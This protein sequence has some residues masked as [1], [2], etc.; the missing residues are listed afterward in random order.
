MRGGSSPNNP[1]PD[2]FAQLD[3]FQSTN[4]RAEEGAK[5]QVCGTALTDE[6][7]KVIGLCDVHQR[8]RRNDKGG[9][10]LTPIDMPA[11]RWTARTNDGRTVGPMTLEDL[12][13]RIRQGELSPADE[14]S[15]DGVSFLPMGKFQEIAYLSSIGAAGDN[16]VGGVPRSRPSYARRGGEGLSRAIT[17][18]LALALIT[19]LAFIGITQK[20]K[21]EEMLGHAGGNAAK[22]GP[23]SPNPLKRS[24]AQWRLAHPDVSGTAHEHL[25]TA[26]AR[27][28]EDTWRGY[29]LAEEAYQRALLLDE[30]D[31]AAISGYVENFAIWRYPIASPEE[32]RTAQAAIKYALE[33]APESPIVHRASAALGLARG[34]L[35]VCRGGADKALE[36]DATDGLA[37]L[38]L[39]GCYLEGNV[40][41]AISE[42]ER[43]A[44]L[45]PELRRADRVLALGYSKVGR[46]ASAM[47]LLDARLKNDPKNG[48]VQLLY[49]HLA[50]DMS[51]LDLAEQHYRAAVDAGGDVQEAH[52]ALAELMLE[53]GNVA[54]AIGEYKKAADQKGSAVERLGRA[55]AGL[56]R[57]EV[58][59]ERPK[60]ALRYARTALTYTPRDPEVL[61]VNGEVA[62]MTGSATTAS[63]LAKRALDARSGEPA[64]L[65]LAGRAATRERARDRAIKSF[66]EAIANDPTDP[67]IKGVLA[68][69][70][71]S[72]GGTQQAYALIRKAAE[73]DPAERVSR[74]R[75]GPLSI[76]DAPVREAIEA[77]RKSAAEEANASVASSSMGMLYY[78]LGDRAHAQDSISRALRIDDSNATGL[79]YDAQ[80]ALDRGDI[81]HAEAAATRMLAIERG[82]SLGHLMLARADAR[83]G[84]KAGAIEQYQ[85]ALRSN[86]G[87]LV[88]KVEL[89]GMQLK[90][91]RDKALAELATAYQVNPHSLV[92]RKLL[93]EADY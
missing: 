49:G 87:L 10:M 28:L 36:K 67:R 31:P 75:T 16:A 17:W 86:P 15:K 92:T 77:F 14:Y 34:E 72:M 76:I 23:T 43:A 83:K 63:A 8:D 29:Q 60:E 26:K 20:D 59:L 25:V 35:N 9:P 68:A 55:Y 27:H 58:L 84:D 3:G 82:A 13:S 65:V 70:Y 47:R 48:A 85:N 6:F 19:G 89:A 93:Y 51:Q 91:E 39:A 4:D 81:K 1:P 80:L 62:L 5:C 78:Q 30:N 38:I 11:A 12:R 46:Y 42:A 50:R 54:G 24:L 37:K 32:T 41:L 57:A 44:K 56:A 40:Q 53:Q 33:A 73:V 61:L 64:A 71:L 45:V 69:S 74:S 21:I 52:L 66:E 2:R 7:D 22:V 79:L 88:A 90:T 18:G